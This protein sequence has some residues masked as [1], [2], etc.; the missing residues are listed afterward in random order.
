MNSQYNEHLFIQAW[1][2]D[3]SGRLLDVGAF[4]GCRSS[5]TLSLLQLGWSGVLVEPSPVTFTKLEENY[6]RLGLMD[7]CILVNAALTGNDM[8][9][10]RQNFYDFVDHSRE[11]GSYC[12]SLKHTWTNYQAK[13][14]ASDRT[15]NLYSI[16]VTAVRPR[17]FIDMYGSDFDFIN[18]DAEGMS[19][20]IA[21][22]M[23][24]SVMSTKLVCIE[25][26]HRRDT[27]IDMMTSHGFTWAEHIGSNLLFGRTV[28]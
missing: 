7:R 21:D 17:D 24:W 3:R 1:F 28:D 13:K 20:I 12:G 22:S 10:G 11:H 16:P 2:G 18:I 26:D 23:P 25:I 4:D 8:P 9:D 27:I 5:N 15:D 19:Q 6:Q 14:I